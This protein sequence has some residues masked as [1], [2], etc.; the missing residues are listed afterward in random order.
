MVVSLFV[1]KGWYEFGNIAVHA[2]V[3]ITPLSPALV[4]SADEPCSYEDIIRLQLSET[5]QKHFCYNVARA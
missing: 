2:L 1:L 5:V 3:R 4:L